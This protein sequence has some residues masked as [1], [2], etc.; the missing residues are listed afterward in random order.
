MKYI[1]FVDDLNVHTFVKGKKNSVI[2]R[3]HA[4]YGFLKWEIRLR[5]ALACLLGKAIAV[6][7]HEDL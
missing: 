5:H 7:F 4:G 2:A 3:P 1:H 6:K